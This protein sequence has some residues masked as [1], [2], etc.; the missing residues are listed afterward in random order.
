MRAIHPA[1]CMYNGQP[2]LMGFYN[3]TVQVCESVLPYGVGSVFLC[4]SD[5]VDTCF[6][7]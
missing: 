5:D 7:R 1:L 6:R 3:C 2:V 4:L